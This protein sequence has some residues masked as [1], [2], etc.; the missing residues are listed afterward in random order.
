MRRTIAVVLASAVFACVLYLPSL[1]AVDDPPPDEKPTDQG[2]KAESKIRSSDKVV[3]KDVVCALEEDKNRLYLTSQPLGGVD[4][5][6]MRVELD[7]TV[8]NAGRIADFALAKLDSKNLQAAIKV[9]V[10]D[11]YQFHCLTFIGPWGGGHVRDDC[12]FFE[13]KFYTT[14]ED[15]KIIAVGGKHLRNVVFIIL[16]DTVINKNL[17]PIIDGVVY[18]RSCPWRPGDGQLSHFSTKSGPPR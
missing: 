8:P 11:K 4:R 5:Q 3:L 2:A 12:E 16:G 14:H 18:Y 15:L 13:E 17:E 1:Q 7:F 6:L 10:G 9:Q